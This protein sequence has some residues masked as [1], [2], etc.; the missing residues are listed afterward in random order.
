[1][2]SRAAC[3]TSPPNPPRDITAA[4]KIVTQVIAGRRASLTPK[5]VADH[6]PGS[7]EAHPGSAGAYP[8]SLP[9]L[10]V[11]T[12]M[13]SHPGS[14]RRRRDRNPVG[15]RLPGVGLP[16]SPGRA[17]RDPGLCCATPSASRGRPTH[18]CPKR[19]S[20]LVREDLPCRRN[21]RNCPAAGH[22]ASRPGRSSISSCQ[23]IRDG[24]AS[25]LLSLRGNSRIPPVV[26]V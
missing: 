18:R 2:A 9:A 5:G 24:D 26:E 19:P 12:P 8:Q 3:A 4:S 13:G 21:I 16:L 11:P 1:M 23:A 17:L 7:P 10:L 15:V 22:H 25:L 20:C 14:R 6:S